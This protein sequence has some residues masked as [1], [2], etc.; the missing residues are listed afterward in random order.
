MA[1]KF[2]LS[3][4]LLIVLMVTGYAR[5]DPSAGRY[6]C[7]IRVADQRGESYFKQEKLLAVKSVY[8]VV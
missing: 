5:K 3:L 2:H 6:L 4:W 1:V 8:A 7:K